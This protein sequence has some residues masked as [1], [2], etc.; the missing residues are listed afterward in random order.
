M[1]IKYI[2]L[3]IFCLIAAVMDLYSCK[4]KNSLIAA[5]IVTGFIFCAHT[6]GMRGLLASAFGLL[7]PLLSLMAF[8]RHG[9][10]G[11]GDLKLFAMTG[12]F[13]GPGKIVYVMVASFLAGAIIGS[14]KLLLS[15]R[16]DSLHKIRFALPTFIGVAFLVFGVI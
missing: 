3:L 6:Q 14:V 5:G 11:A 2:V 15:E 16:E 4:V 1:E 7:I 13:T 10:F 9:F 8:Y 12:A